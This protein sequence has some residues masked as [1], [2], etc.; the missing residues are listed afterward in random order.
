MP[1]EAEWEYAAR[2]GA[3]SINYKY[4]GGNDLDEVGWHWESSRLEPRSICTTKK[5][6][7]LGL[8]DMSGNVWEWC[9]DW[10]GEY[11]SLP[12]IH[13]R[14]PSVGLERILRGGSVC[15]S[16]SHCRVTDRDKAEPSHKDVCTGFR[17]A[18]N[19]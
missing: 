4:S 3:K 1:T 2:G 19:P 12:K 15:N 9:W 17:L 6:N 14:G 18:R 7:E 8:C 16:A 11:N 13:P 10:Y 5:V